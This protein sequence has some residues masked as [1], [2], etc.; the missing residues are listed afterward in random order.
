MKH[1]IIFLRK[2]NDNLYVVKTIVKK[3]I[4]QELL[5]I[6][7]KSFRIVTNS[8]GYIHYAKILGWQSIEFVH[9]VNYDNGTTYSFNDIAGLDPTAL[10]QIVNNKTVAQ[11]TKG[12]RESTNQFNWISLLLGLFI[13]ISAILLIQYF[14]PK[15]TGGNIIEI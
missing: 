5:S 9:F 2:E 12:I 4:S 10:D 15:T 1:K 3:D 13:G 8:P 6:T 7:K 11:I 14:I